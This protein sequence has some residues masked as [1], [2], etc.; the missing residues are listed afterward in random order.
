MKLHE[1]MMTTGA[2]QTEVA[3]RLGVSQSYLS[4]I[5]A[6][7]R[8]SSRIRGRRPSPELAMRIVELTGGQVSLNEA[9][10]PHLQRDD[11]RQDVQGRGWT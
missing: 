2:T 3:R 1:Y 9:L 5:L 7:E 6:T 8:Q 11:E 10:F 4:E